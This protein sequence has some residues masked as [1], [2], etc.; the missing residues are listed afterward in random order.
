MI[1][2]ED[3]HRVRLVTLDRPDALNAFNEAL[4][5]A[6]A[7]ALAAAAADPGVAVA[8]L[9]GAGR[10]FCAGTD[11]P[12]MAA[13][14]AGTLAPGRHGFPGLV[15][16]LAAFPKPL[17]L[18]VNGIGVGIGATMLGFAD[19]ALMSTEARLRCPFTRL[20]VAPEAAS[21]YTF[22][23]LVGRQ[24]A[25][26][27]L[28]SSEWLSAQECLAMGLVWKLCAPAELLPETLRCARVLAAKPIA[29]LVETKAAIVA[30]S[31]DAIAAARRREDAAFQRLLG[32]PAN[33]EAFRAFAEK[34]EPDF[35]A[36]D[37]R[38]ASVRAE[39]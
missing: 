14:V 20:A 38:E 32:S 19:L 39:G 29:S 31:R 25:S 8:V 16:R 34:R 4:Y 28:L 35:A 11:V 21:S 36:V 1:R 3:S 7:D 6:V 2:V 30:A 17:L 23:Q 37:A 13:R 33:L 12:E 9:T 27:A 22:P 15:D 18:A 26:W 10:A 24:H 5:D